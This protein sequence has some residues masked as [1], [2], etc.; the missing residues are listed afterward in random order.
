MWIVIGLGVWV[1][2]LGALMGTL[3][4]SGRESRR[5]EALSRRRHLS[6]VRPRRPRSALRSAPEQPAEAK[7]QPETQQQQ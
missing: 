4:V 1:A 7:G 3:A 6:L 2:A 5:E